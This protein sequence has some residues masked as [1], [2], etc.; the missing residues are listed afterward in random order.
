MKLTV[1]SERGLFAIRHA[2]APMR[3]DDERGLDCLVAVYRR[4]LIVARII[5][6]S[7]KLAWDA[8][9]VCAGIRFRREN[10]AEAE[11]A[12]QPFALAA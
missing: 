2:I 10:M 5:C 4:G 3:H 1:A 12:E 11:A 6:A 8:E 7:A 9:R